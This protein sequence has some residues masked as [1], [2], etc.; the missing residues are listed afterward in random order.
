MSYLIHIQVSWT[1]SQNVC[2]R[3]VCSNQ[4]PNKA[5]T[6]LSEVFF[7][8][9]QWPPDLWQ[10]SGLLPGTVPVGWICQVA[11]LSRRLPGCGPPCMSCELESHLS[12]WLDSVAP[13]LARMLPGWC[14]LR[15]ASHR[16]VHA[17]HCPLLEM[18][19]VATRFRWVHPHPSSEKL[20]FPCSRNESAAWWAGTWWIYAPPR[21]S[22]HW[23]SSPGSTFH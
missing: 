8:P 11:S 22:P 20:R 21:T 10:S 18:I 6:R 13:L 23:R 14:A 17:A 4:D 1:I 9:A 15:I 7:T 12:I 19:R 16:E 3:L 2:K 5:V